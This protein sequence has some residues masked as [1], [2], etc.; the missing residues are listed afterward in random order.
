MVCLKYIR[1][2]PKTHF[3]EN[4]NK[5]IRRRKEAIWYIFPIYYSNNRPLSDTKQRHVNSSLP[6]IMKIDG[7]VL[8]ESRT[9]KPQRP[10]FRI[11]RSQSQ[12]RRFVSP[13]SLQYF[14]VIDL[15]FSTVTDY[16]PLAPTNHCT[17]LSFPL[18]KFSPV[19]ATPSSD[20]NRQ[21]Q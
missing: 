5:L 11:L 13:R 12:P 21:L 8:Q 3:H 10:G 7:Y 2:S 20:K 17:R 14:H 15:L 1:S 4:S 16:Q 19:M 6:I 18:A 9:S